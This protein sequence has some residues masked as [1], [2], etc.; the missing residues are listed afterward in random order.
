M[1]SR[2]SLHS[3]IFLRPGGVV[4]QCVCGVDVW[5]WATY[6]NVGSSKQEHIAQISHGRAPL[7]TVLHIWTFCPLFIFI[8]IFGCHSLLSL[9]LS[10]HLGTQSHKTDNDQHPPAYL[11]TTQLVR[12]TMEA[13]QGTETMRSKKLVVWIHWLNGKVTPSDQSRICF[14]VHWFI[15]PY[16]CI[17]QGSRIYSIFNFTGNVKWN[18][19]DI[20]GRG[21]LLHIV[22]LW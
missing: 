17:A 15:D 14:L 19:R 5:C 12:V 6:A 20:K 16:L 4:H 18:P 11:I 1:I 8:F 2:T 7:C 21:N 10:Y 22:F 3:K 13:L 9:I